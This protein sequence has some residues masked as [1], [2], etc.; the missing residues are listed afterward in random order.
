MDV[1]KQVHCRLLLPPEAHEH[2]SDTIIVHR[3]SC[4]LSRG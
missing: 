3:P 1:G 2:T 4:G